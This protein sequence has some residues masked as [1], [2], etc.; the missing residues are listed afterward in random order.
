MFADEMSPGVPHQRKRQVWRV[1]Q[2]RMM[3]TGSIYLHPTRGNLPR[4]TSRGY[5]GW[6]EDYPNV[7][8][9]SSNQGPQHNIFLLVGAQV[10]RSDPLHTSTLEI[11]LSTIPFDGFPLDM[12]MRYL[13]LHLPLP[14]EQGAIYRLLELFSRRY[15]TCN[16]ALWDSHDQI[17]VVC[18]SILM[19]NTDVWNSNNKTKM[20]REQYVRN[21]AGQGASEDILSVRTRNAIS[22]IHLF[23]FLVFFLCVSVCFVVCWLVAYGIISAGTITSR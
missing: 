15:L 10:D 1:Q 23:F 14:K 2:P 8:R 19:L 16:P 11:Y 18:Y 22:H 13:L 3:T 21:T 17:L 9:N 4:S 6:K 20:T 12:A 5:K 7:S